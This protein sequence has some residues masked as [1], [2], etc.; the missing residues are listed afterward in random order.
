MTTTQPASNSFA[1]RLAHTDKKIRDKAVKALGKWLSSREDLDQL[2]LLK[3]W[4]GLF[5]CF[6]MSDKPLIQQQLSNTL[7]T[8]ILDLPQTIA[9]PFVKAFWEIIVR[10]WNGIDRYR[11]DKFYLLLRRYVN[12]TCTLL[13]N[14]S[15]DTELVE[16]Y[17]D[18]MKSGVFNPSNLQIPNSVRTHVADLFLE[19][20]D[21][22]VPT[23]KSEEVP[24]EKILE[25]FFYFIARNP[26]KLVY[27]R[28]QENL[29]QPLSERIQSE[30]SEQRRYNYA[31]IIESLAELAAD[32]ETTGVKRRRINQ[33]LQAIGG[34]PKEPEVLEDDS[35]DVEEPEIVEDDVVEPSNTDS[36]KR[37]RQKKVPESAEA[38]EAVQEDK[39]KKKKKQKAVEEIPEAVSE[40]VQ[41]EEPKKVKKQKV[42]EPV[43]VEEPK[44]KKK[45][46][47]AEEPAAA[48]PIEVAQPVKAKTGKKQKKQAIVEEAAEPLAVEETITIEEP[49]KK[50]SK[51]SKKQ[52]IVEPETAVEA[53][54]VEVTLKKSKKVK[55]EKEVTPKLVE[56]STPLSSASKKSVQWGLE[57]NSVKRFKK[58]LPVSPMP[59]PVASDRKPMKSALKKSKRSVAANPKS[60]L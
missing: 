14:S 32:A 30:E 60:S 44:K 26:N 17:V 40:P 59:S 48:E 34:T 22:V 55:A 20:L 46:K 9:I 36:K 56:P 21:K 3:L 58:Q 37:K 7:A 35:M 47:V 27:T 19:E 52:K 31:S 51:K 18:M 57:N 11:L 8:M 50:L 23:E 53:P 2:E 38:N 29:L 54:E 5:Y 10:E 41:E 1:K 24:M 13:M 12:S 4:K 43:Q 6:W 49:V 39:K 16:Q 42:V 15:W 45:Q 33:F 25:P 28:L